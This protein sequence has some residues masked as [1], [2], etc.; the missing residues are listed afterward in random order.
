MAAI[1]IKG[2]EELQKKLGTA[3][4][5][6]TLRRPM[7]RSVKRLQADMQKYPPQPAGVTYRRGQDPRSEDLGASWT[8]KVTRSARGLTGKVGNN[9]SYA[10]WVQS[11]QFQALH[12]GYWQTDQEVI[13]KNIKPIIADFKRAID[14][15]LR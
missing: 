14:R 1:E 10:P 4:T 11:H 7:E 13:D 6:K 8:S 5:T 9:T 15:A 3:G 2:V 12:M